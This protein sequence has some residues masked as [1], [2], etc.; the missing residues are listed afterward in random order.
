MKLF[1]NSYGKIKYLHDFY[2]ITGIITI[3]DYNLAYLVNRYDFHYV[4]GQSTPIMII[5]HTKELEQ[6]LSE[7][8][9]LGI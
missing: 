5:D 2:H 4:E 9:Y 7:I 3:S 8:N 6:H 1:Q